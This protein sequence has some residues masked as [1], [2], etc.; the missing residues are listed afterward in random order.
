MACEFC[1]G[2]GGGVLFNCGPFRVVTVDEPDYPGFV[3]LIANQHAKEMTDL[4]PDVQQVLLQAVLL[5]E[6]VMRATLGPHKVNLASLG[7]VT[8]HV[9]WHVIPRFADDRHFP[10]PIWAEPMRE[11]ADG[12]VAALRLESALRFHNELGRAC[13]D[14]FA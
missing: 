4:P 3:R 13:R 6:R 9:H 1:D 14:Q 11:R 12:R 5:V 7:N 8:P 10:R 2:P